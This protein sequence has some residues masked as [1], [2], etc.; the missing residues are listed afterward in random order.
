MTERTPEAAESRG[1]AAAAGKLELCRWRRRRTVWLVVTV[2][3]AAVWVSSAWWGVMWIAEDR[4]DNVVF[5]GAGVGVY[6]G[7]RPL[8]YWKGAG[9]GFNVYTSNSPQ[10]LWLPH[11]SQRQGITAGVPLWFLPVAAGVMWLRATRC[12]VRIRCRLEAGCCSGCGYELA[13]VRTEGDGG[14]VCPECGERVTDTQRGG[15]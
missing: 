5:N 4:S 2:V 15:K 12:S 1:S 13:G 6:I 14:V 8:H 11:F 10:F 9:P 7:D 3:L